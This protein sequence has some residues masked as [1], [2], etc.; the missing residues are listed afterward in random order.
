MT[1]YR[2][3]VVKKICKDIANGVSQKIAAVCAGITEETFHQWL[4]KSEFSERI[5]KARNKAIEGV[6]DALRKKARGEIE[7]TEET[8]RRNEKGKMELVETKTRKYAPDVTALIFWLCNK[9]PDVWENIQK[10][11]HSGEIKILT[12][13]DIDNAIKAKQKEEKEKDV[14]PADK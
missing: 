4:K 8:Y 10:K 14:T 7:R 9:H 1:K 3:S 5:E 2:E 6:E 12:A 13:I 11:I